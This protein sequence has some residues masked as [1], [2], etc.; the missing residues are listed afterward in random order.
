MVFGSNTNPSKVNWAKV[1][2]LWGI[3]VFVIYIL[4]EVVFGPTLFNA[5]NY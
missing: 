4:I 5:F 3:I 1:A 2:L